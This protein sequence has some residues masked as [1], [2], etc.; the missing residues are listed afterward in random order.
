MKID[1]E[2]IEGDIFPEFS[3]VDL[4]TKSGR[5]IEIWE[6]GDVFIT[7]SNNDS[8]I[9]MRVEELIEIGRIYKLYKYKRDAYILS[10]KLLSK[11]IDGV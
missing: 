9:T 2:Y 11:I 6:D 3:T 7:T 10:K 1:S 8:Y 4:K 5:D